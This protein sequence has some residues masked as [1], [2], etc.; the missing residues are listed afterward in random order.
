MKARSVD[1]PIP[2]RP[3]SPFPILTDYVDIIC[4]F[5]R[6][7]S[8]L[9][10]PTANVPIEQLPP[11]VN[12]LE[13]GVYFG[14]SKLH[15]ITSLES[16]THERKNGTLVEYNYGKNLTVDDT[17]VLPVVMSVGWNPF[18][19]NKSKTVELHIL[20][21]FEDDFYGAKVKFSL[22]GY[23]R[24]E[25]DYTT[26]ENLIDD[27]HTDIKITSEVLKRPGYSCLRRQLLE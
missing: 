2:D 16:K 24:P 3:V 14:W 22:L 13:T 23:I 17:E 21:A 7:S 25:L 18:F 12:T 5:G 26:K 19:K 8:E 11:E 6:G 10:I 9:G 27:I 20:R 4:G 1:V 15:A